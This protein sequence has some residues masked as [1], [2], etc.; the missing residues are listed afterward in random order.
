MNKEIKKTG[1]CKRCGR[2]LKNKKSIEIGFGKTCL[3][4]YL[5]DIKKSK[6][7]KLF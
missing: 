2:V 3:K 4:K 6:F 1:K 5:K 7:Y